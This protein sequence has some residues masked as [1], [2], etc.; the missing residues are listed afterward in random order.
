MGTVDN[1]QRRRALAFLRSAEEGREWTKLA[2]ARCIYI[3]KLTLR[4][5]IME[6]DARGKSQLRPAERETLCSTAR[7]NFSIVYFALGEDT[8]VFRNIFGLFLLVGFV[9]V[10]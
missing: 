6:R 8:T 3:Y 2:S 7:I 9:C 10:T 5:E 4:N 1:G